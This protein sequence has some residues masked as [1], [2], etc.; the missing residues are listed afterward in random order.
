MM[1]TNPIRCNLVFNGIDFDVAEED[2]QALLEVANKKSFLCFSWGAF[3]TAYAR[4][5][6]EEAIRLCTYGADGKGHDKFVYCDTDSVKFIGNVD[7]T[8]LNNRLRDLSIRHGA[9]ADD[10]QGNRYYLGVYEKDGTYSRFCTLG[11]KKYVYEDEDNKLHITI[12]G[13]NK[14]SG[15]R[16][17]GKIENFKEGFVFKESAGMEAV[18]NDLG[19]EPIVVG[20]H[21]LEIPPNIY[22]GQSEYTLG[23]TMEYK[24]LFHLTQEQLDK[25]AK[26]R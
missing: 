26:T 8:A 1:A 21:T 19:H 11:A 7:F 6:L 18:Y 17:L 14:Q 4:E 23:V 9:F 13:V 3:C 24:A 15:A 2:E 5:K 25:I 12:A 22:L 20:G 10:T 16:E